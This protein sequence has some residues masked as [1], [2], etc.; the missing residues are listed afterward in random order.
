MRSLT[1]IYICWTFMETNQW[2]WVLWGNG[3]CISAVMT[4]MGKTSH[5]PGAHAQLSQHKMKS[6]LISSS[7]QIGELQPGNCVWGWILASLCWKWWWQHWNIAKFVPG[8]SR[9]GS[10][11]SRKNTVC[12]FGKTYWTNTRLKVTVSWITSFLMMR[13]GVTTVSRSQNNILWSSDMWIPHR[14]QS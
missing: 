10:Q 12:K 2:M 1:F 9:E 11:R 6:I 4:A 5:I 13:H 3:S 8:G 14:R 7:M